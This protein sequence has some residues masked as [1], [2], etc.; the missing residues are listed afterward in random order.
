VGGGIKGDGGG[1]GGHDQQVV[2]MG[3]EGFLR[4]ESLRVWP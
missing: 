4:A 3:R 2:L 1:R